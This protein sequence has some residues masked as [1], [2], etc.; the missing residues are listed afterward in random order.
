MS[1]SAGQV[2]GRE[3]ERTGGSGGWG[4]A[5]VGACTA[6]EPLLGA[7]CLPSCSGAWKW[8]RKRKWKRSKSRSFR[9]RQE[10]P[11]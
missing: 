3:G 8:K 7:A 5:L 9:M 2:L 6:S 1:D 4:S 10:T 11:P